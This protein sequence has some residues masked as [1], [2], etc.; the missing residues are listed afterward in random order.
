MTHRANANGRSADRLSRRRWLAVGA[1]AVC[2]GILGNARPAAAAEAARN[3]AEAA[4]QERSQQNRSPQS[5]AEGTPKE[6]SL[7][8]ID[9]HAHVWSDDVT[10][11]PLAG[12]QTVADL[13]PRRFLPEEL[14]ELAR[15]EGV[16]RIVLIQHSVYHLW[17]NRYL[18]D[19]TR[20]FPGRFA[21]LGMVDDRQPQAAEKLR[22]LH[23]QGV[24][25]LRIT[26]RIH[27]PRWLEGE[28]MAS[29]WQTAAQTGQVMG[30]LIDPEHL[31]QLDAMCQ[32]FPQTR[33]VIDH[34]ARLGADGTIRPADVAQ[35][36][37]LARHRHV[38]VK[39]SAFYALGKKQPPYDDLLP[40]IRRVLDAFGPARCM[41]A[42]DA[43]YQVQ[44]PHTYAASISLIRDRL[45]GLSAGDR[46]WLLAR[47]SEEFFFT[48]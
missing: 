7:P 33:V 11:W 36:C 30:C 4:L 39:V 12:E 21:V 47:T 34:M 42:S 1:S 2:A 43:P 16:G 24:R 26:P 27:G 41:W 48:A 3:A 6:G 22:S 28:G 37:R 44:P 23:E 25:G 40:L 46:Q 10:R 19:C 9:A 14:L 35:L 15:P 32:R 18:I 17:D 8:W 31:P 29:L 5:Q 38:A 13:K 20:R 45:E